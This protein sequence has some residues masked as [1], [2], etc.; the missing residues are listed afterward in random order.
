MRVFVAC[1]ME[2]HSVL[3]SQN[4]IWY[5]KDILGQGATG[6]VYKGRHRVREIVE[7]SSYCIFQHTK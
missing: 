1:G 7:K 5:T 2:T 4:Y 3:G 6:A